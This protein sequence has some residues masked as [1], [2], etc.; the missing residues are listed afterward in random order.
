M[1]KSTLSNIQ[2]AV[3]HGENIMQLSIE[4]A[5][6]YATIEEIM[7]ALFGDKVKA[8]REV[9]RARHRQIAV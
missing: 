4:A 1:V 9:I 5:K 2:E 6:A 8:Y 3:K 7:N